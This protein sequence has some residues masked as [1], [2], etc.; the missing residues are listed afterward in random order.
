MDNVKTV[1]AILIYHHHKPVD[2]NFV[3]YLQDEL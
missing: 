2:Q 1:I 3:A